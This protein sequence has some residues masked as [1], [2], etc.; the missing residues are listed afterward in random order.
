MEDIYTKIRE[1]NKKYYGEGVDSYGVY[2][3][4]KLYSD[5]THFIYELIQNA[6]DASKRANKEGKNDFSISFALYPDR[7]EVRNNGAL[8]NEKDIRAISRIGDGTKKNDSTQIGKFGLGFKSVYAYTTSPEIHSGDKS[9]YLKNYVYPYEI[10]DKVALDSNESLF[11]IPFNHNEITKEVAYN[12]IKNRLKKLGNET[13]LFLRYVN[14]IKWTIGHEKGTYKRESNRESYDVRTVDIISSYSS[15]ATNDNLKQKFLI[16]EQRL[17]QCRDFPVEIAYKLEYDD[18]M[19]KFKIVSIPEAKL[20]VFFLT[21]LVTGLK[22]IIQGPYITTP[23]RNDIR[24]DEAWNKELIEQTSILVSN[25]ISRIKELG[26]LT[27]S[28]LNTLPLTDPT[29]D[30]IIY[31]PIFKMVFAKLS[32]NQK[33][34]PTTEGDY[35]NAKNALIGRTDELRY[36]LSSEQINTLF[37]KQ[38]GSWISSDIT[39]EKENTLYRYLNDKLSVPFVDPEYFARRINKEFLEEQDDEWIAKFYTF[40]TDKP[41]LW[42]AKEKFIDEGVLRYVEIIRL[43]DNTHVCTFNKNGEPVVYI[44]GEYKL[45]VP[46]VKSDICYDPKIKSFMINLG[47]R[48]PDLSDCVVK[49]ILV[50][51]TSEAEPVIEN[52]E[53]NKRDVEL[54]FKILNQI[55]H[56]EKIRLVEQLKNTNF[57]MAK[58]YQNNIAFKIP[59]KIYLG[60]EYTGNNELEIYYE[61]EKNIFFLDSSYKNIVDIALLKEIGC[62]TKINVIFREPDMRDHVTISHVTRNY[63]RGLDGFDPDCEITGLYNALENQSIEKSKIVW[64]L[65]K[66]HYCRIYGIIESSRKNSYQDSEKKEQF[67][68]MGSILSNLSWLPSKD[69]LFFKPS[70]ITLN[71]LHPDFNPESPEAKKVAEKLKFK[72]DEELKIIEQLSPDK[73][74]KFQLMEKLFLVM[75]EESVEKIIK[76][77]EKSVQKSTLNSHATVLDKFKENL[78]KESTNNQNESEDLRV[79]T[80]MNPEDVEN[81]IE[82]EREKIPE[83]IETSHVETT[84]RVV[85]QKKI[86]NSEQDIDPRVFLMTEYNGS[87]QICNTR[88]LIGENKPYF[89]IYKI[90]SNINSEFNILCLCPNCNTLMK[91]ADKDLSSINLEAEKI[92]KNEVGTEEVMER[93]GDYFIIE[94]ILAGRKLFLYYSPL[95]MAKLAALL[96][97]KPVE[98]NLMEENYV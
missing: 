35:T 76:E 8:F 93:V 98:Q 91:Y 78:L 25:S 2:L 81:A 89:E 66:T 13:L 7:L 56:Q 32:S 67:S 12:E 87:C 70:E 15:V 68:T 10:L 19:N 77:K 52:F 97:S 20:S 36:L 79:W 90:I 26:Y 48:Q 80:G 50:K 65:L 39:R 59:N 43:E 40:L 1:D 74:K 73:K 38:Q 88:L 60:S 31:E 95:H 51:Y 9:F 28:F 58:D 75:D 24:L 22:F 94:I 3:A 96:S 23:A 92:L 11:V 6:E 61:G 5:R 46:T 18:K 54:I 17:E 44:P 83:K 64:N 29:T 63:K 57:L 14:E 49:G 69:R 45:D 86:I 82:N 55:N 37:L 30:N 62:K 71:D 41:A 85:S 16:F 4:D 21:N 33:L 42:R 34:L 84:V 72:S 53:E 47:L 27:I